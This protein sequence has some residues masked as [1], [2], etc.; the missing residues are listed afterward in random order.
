MGITVTV[1]Q[2]SFSIRFRRVC[3]AFCA[4]ALA[5]AGAAPD[6]GVDA[7]SA[8][9]GDLKVAS[10]RAR[11]PGQSLAQPLI[12]LPV[13]NDASTPPPDEYQL[14]RATDGSGDL[15]YEAAGFTARV[16]RDGSVGFRARHLS[17]ISLLPLLPG[18]PP[19]GVPTLESTLRGLGRKKRPSGSEPRRDPTTDE[20][21]DP[22]TTVSRYRPDPREI[23]QYPRPCF[24]DAPV[25][26]LGV[27]A[28]F[29]L[30]DEL[31]RFAGQDPY[32][33]QEAHF[34]AATHE[35]R[36][37]MAA[38][39]HA[40][41][42]AQSRVELAGRLRSIACDDRQR[43]P[44]RRAIIQ[45]LR[46]ELDVTAPAGRAQAEEIGRF[47]EELDRHDGGARCPAP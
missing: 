40:E 1:L 19:H 18:P 46:A 13:A 29:D 20:T 39:A 31:M 37:R 33:Y 27:R 15:I 6:R 41:D 26:L 24:F 12:A 34:L 21:R 8:P 16:A 35:M 11:A 10:P 2:I 9:P 42:L 17:K 30:T 38:H 14:R 23:C 32:R 28:G 25:M 45:A 22:S 47:L 44:E 4:L 7:G 5:A 36:V 3:R 43:P